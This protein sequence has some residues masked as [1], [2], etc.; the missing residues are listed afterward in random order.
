LIESINKIRKDENGNTLP[1]KSYEEIYEVYY[2]NRGRFQSYFIESTIEICQL[3]DPSDWRAAGA[4]K[5][6]FYD[7]FKLEPGAIVDYTNMINFLPDRLITERNEIHQV[8][9]KHCQGKNYD[10]GIRRV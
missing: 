5:A 9:D 10:I 4:I 3:P 2:P 7:K 8:V 6:K 1:P